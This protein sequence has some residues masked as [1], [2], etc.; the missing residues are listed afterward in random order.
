[1]IFYIPGYAGTPPHTRDIIYS[2][3]I[4]DRKDYLEPVAVSAAE[5]ALSAAAQGF[6][7]MSESL[8]S[9]NFKENK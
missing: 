2:A 1:M 8:D 3:H 4:P 5:T 9:M 7:G 6:L